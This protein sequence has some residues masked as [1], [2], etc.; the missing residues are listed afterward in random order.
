MRMLLF[1]CGVRFWVDTVLHTELWDAVDDSVCNPWITGSMIKPYPPSLFPHLCSLLISFLQGLPLFSFEVWTL[2]T[3]GP[4]VRTIIVLHICSM[5]TVTISTVIS[6]PTSHL[7]SV[8]SALSCQNHGAPT[9]CGNDPLFTLS[10]A[11]GAMASPCLPRGR[12]CLSLTRY[13][14][15]PLPGNL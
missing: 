1:R 7:R 5:A 15:V 10:F 2:K 14:Y 11:P 4:L 8:S 3:C 12:H 9:V 6:E 13:K